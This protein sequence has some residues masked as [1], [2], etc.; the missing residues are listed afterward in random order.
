M[1]YGVTLQCHVTSRNN[2]M[3]SSDVTKIR[4]HLV[5]ERT[6]KYM[7]QEVC[8]RSGVFITDV[9]S[10]HFK[11]FTELKDVLED[12]RRVVEKIGSPKGMLNKL[13]SYALSGSDKDKIALIRERLKLLSEATVFSIFVIIFYY[14]M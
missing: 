6:V 8:E 10:I 11:S 2:I 3:T 5:P 9:V 14:F 4:L 7:M 13:K 12:T 1:D